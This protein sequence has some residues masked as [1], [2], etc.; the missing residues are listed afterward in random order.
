MIVIGG[1]CNS[2]PSYQHRV[3]EISIVGTEL[4]SMWISFC[5]LPVQGEIRANNVTCICY[6]VYLDIYIYEVQVTLHIYTWS[7]NILEGC[8]QSALTSQILTDIIMMKIF[9]IS[10]TDKWRH[11]LHVF[12]KCLLKQQSQSVQKGKMPNDERKHS[13]RIHI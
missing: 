11:T 3:P 7:N 8:K 5:L 1:R 2:I 12:M 9:A 10:R 6:T 13:L 4:I